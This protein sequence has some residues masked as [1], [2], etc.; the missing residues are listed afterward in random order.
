MHETLSG[1][2]WDSRRW[3]LVEHFLCVLLHEVH[4]QFIRR[5][6]FF[7]FADGLE[8]TLNTSSAQTFCCVLLRLA[9][10]SADNKSYSSFLFR[11][12]LTHT[13]DSIMSCIRFAP[14]SRR[15]PAFEPL[16]CTDKMLW[17]WLSL[18]HQFACFSRLKLSKLLCLR[19]VFEALTHIF[20]VS[21]ILLCAEIFFKYFFI[22]LTRGMYFSFVIIFFLL[23]NQLE[24]WNGKKFLRTSRLHCT[25]NSQYIS[26]PSG[27]SAAPR[28][29]PKRSWSNYNKQKKLCQSR[30]WQTTMLRCDLKA[31]RGQ[32]RIFLIFCVGNFENK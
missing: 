22:L 9:F 10:C 31:K 24:G 18:S 32:K 12:S 15:I 26:C 14:S 5:R 16:R 30:R 3:R 21:L 1:F 11:V 28:F 25:Y 13:R 23:F 19:F 8:D 6:F 20:L 2:T 27:V 7:C 4:T 29:N 17:I